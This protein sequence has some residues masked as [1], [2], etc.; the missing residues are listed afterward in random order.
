MSWYRRAKLGI[1]SFH[2]LT[3][4]TAQLHRKIPNSSFQL[5]GNTIVPTCKPPTT[6]FQRYY[7]VERNQ[8]IGAKRLYQLSV[9]AIVGTGLWAGFVFFRLGVR[10]ENVPYTNRKHI[11]VCSPMQEKLLANSSL[12]KGK[13]KY[14]GKLLDEKDPHSVR[15]KLILKNI[16]QGLERE[17]KRNPNSTASG[18]NHYDEFNW[19]I[20]VVDELEI[21]AFAMAGGTI[22]IFSGTLEV[23]TD[24][25]VAA[26]IGHEV[27]HVVARHIFESPRSLS[28][29]RKQE[30][31]ADYIGLLLMASAGYNPRAAPE[32][33][34]KLSSKYPDLKQEDH[35]EHLS[36]EERANLLSQAHVMEQALT[37]YEKILEFTELLQMFR[38]D[39]VI[40]AGIAL[41][42]QHGATHTVA[43]HVAEVFRKLT[44]DCSCSK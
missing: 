9:L 14:K 17:V 22:F 23:L 19:N 40:D 11:V 43:R 35:D 31:E 3:N 26:I 42:F 28:I 4:S 44:K 12:E 15:A 29:R 13:T 41:S 7:N 39:T 27:A 30:L 36:F 38:S 8:D 2:N 25:D 16:I 10:I 37:I 5:Y 33:W 21:N 1:T 20:L 6:S 24:G 18:F 32:Y 34:W